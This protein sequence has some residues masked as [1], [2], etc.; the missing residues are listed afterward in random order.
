MTGVAMTGVAKRSVY[1]PPMLIFPRLQY[2]VLGL[3]LPLLWLPKINLIAVSGQY[4]GARVDD[5]ILLLAAAVVVVVWWR[6]L[7][8]L[9]WFLYALAGFCILGVG[10]V[11][12]NGGDFIGYAY[13]LR[14]AEYGVFFIVGSLLADK[15]RFFTMYLGAYCLVT[16]ALVVLQQQGLAPAFTTEDG[17]RWGIPSGLTGGTWE[18]GLVLALLAAAG[19]QAR[20]SW[21]QKGV[22]L[23]WAGLGIV[24]SGARVPFVL[25]LGVAA[26]GRDWRRWAAALVLVPLVVGFS[27]VGKR[28]GMLVSG[29]NIV[30][31]RGIWH[32]ATPEMPVG[33]AY[34]LATATHAVLPAT[35]LSLLQ[36]SEKTAVAVKLFWHSRDTM[37]FWI[38][39]G[40]GSRGTAV[41][42]GYARLLAENGVVGTLLMGGFFFGGLLVCPLPTIVLLGNMLTL[43]AYLAYK[44]MTVYFLLLGFVRPHKS[45]VL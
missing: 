31:V 18:V 35:D 41:D 12:W 11:Y 3:L 24:M 33:D 29:D 43:D 13:A 36:R 37:A 7:L 23:L 9:P 8:A 25:L 5:G 34:P 16:V 19:L 38:G 39:H 26:V 10:S 15:P 17:L 40:P 2:L 32:A 6:V 21:Q 44:V 1:I 20:L 42:M 45:L 30:A 28:L 14:L 27:P 22:A 4:A